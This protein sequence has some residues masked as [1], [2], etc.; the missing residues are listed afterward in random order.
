MKDDK[1]PKG[2]KGYCID[3]LDEIAK[4]VKFDYV[5]QEVEDQKFGNM[6]D[7]GEWNGIVR[8]LI[9]KQAD[10]GLG[11]MHNAICCFSYWLMCI[12]FIRFNVGDGRTRDGYRFHGSLLRFGRSRHSDAAA[13]C[14]QLS[15]QI[16]DRSRNKCM[17][18]YSGRI[19]LHKV[20]CRK[21]LSKRNRNSH[22]L[23]PLQF[24]VVDIRSLQPIQ[25]PKQSR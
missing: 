24:I 12:P 25:L 6:D 17:A 2:F 7:D 11:S 16:F 8:K 9:D 14:P 13:Q 5:I 18:L 3:L 22:I 4:L 20:N 19:L 21:C 23:L 10:I 1:A 15:F